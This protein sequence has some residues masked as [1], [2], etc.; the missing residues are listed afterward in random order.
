MSDQKKVFLTDSFINSDEEVICLY[1]INYISDAKTPRFD[2][3]KIANSEESP[4]IACKIHIN[5]KTG[6]VFSIEY[7]IKPN[8]KPLELYKPQEIKEIVNSTEFVK[9]QKDDGKV[10]YGRDP[11]PQI[12]STT[13]TNYKN[14]DKVLQLKITSLSPSK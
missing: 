14:R 12:I 5:N 1:D 11:L 8:S 3:E 13:M 6:K 4:K 7:G 10:D 9:V 2:I